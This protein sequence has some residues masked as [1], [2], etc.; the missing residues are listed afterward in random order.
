MG[1]HGWGWGSGD[2]W[3]CSAGAELRERPGVRRGQYCCFAVCRRGQEVG[4]PCG[5]P[6]TWGF[7]GLRSVLGRPGLGPAL[8]FVDCMT[9]GKL[10][11]P[12]SLSVTLSFLNWEMGRRI[13]TP[14][15][16]TRLRASTEN[17]GAA[18]CAGAPF[19]G[20]ALHQPHGHR[21]PA[22]FYH[23]R[24][25]GGQLGGRVARFAGLCP[26]EATPDSPTPQPGTPAD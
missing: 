19:T 5:N 25:L 1:K 21:G 16:E 4:E 17:D 3:T 20:V 7:G 12:L 22:C 8:P 11:H 6:G 14:Q 2:T 10:L 15:R 26:G 23:P 9:L 13:P 18:K 24:D